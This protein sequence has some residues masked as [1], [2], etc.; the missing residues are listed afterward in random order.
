[1]LVLFF[2]QNEHN[3]SIKATVV[4]A[5][6]LTDL[7]SKF[8]DQCLKEKKKKILHAGWLKDSA[9]RNDIKCTH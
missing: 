3:R 2:F 4:V 7:V 1:M 6:V 8:Q 5:R 9:W